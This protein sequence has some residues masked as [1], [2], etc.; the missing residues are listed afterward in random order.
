MLGLV[1]SIAMLSAIVAALTPDERWDERHNPTLPPRQTTWGPEALPVGPPAAFSGILMLM[2]EPFPAYRLFLAAAG[3][4]VAVRTSDP[5]AP[6][7]LPAWCRIM[8][9][10][11]LGSVSGTG[12]TTFY[13]RK[14]D[15]NS[16]SS[17][18]P[19]R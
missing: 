4:V 2:G 9:R 13:F 8:S 18:K 14:G 19:D 17:P 3:A 11:F 12:G 16:S 10:T 1:L 7:D 15:A 5:S 6:H